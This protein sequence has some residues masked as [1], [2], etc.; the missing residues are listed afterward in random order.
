M[1]LDTIQQ[2]QAQGIPIEYVTPQN[3][4]QAPAK[5]YPGMMWRQLSETNF[6]DNLPPGA[7]ECRTVD[8]DPGL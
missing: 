6:V 3:E 8:A 4:P 1:S 5:N 7:R 2:Y